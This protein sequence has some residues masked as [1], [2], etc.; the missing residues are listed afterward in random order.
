MVCVEKNRN[1]TLF[2]Y[3]IF[4]GRFSNKVTN[5]SDQ[6]YLP[7]DCGRDEI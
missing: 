4:T 5:I 3:F 2:D 7:T 1:I 6:R